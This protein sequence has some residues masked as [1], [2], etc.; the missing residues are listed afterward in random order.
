MPKP[1]VVFMGDSLTEWMPR[2]K[3]NN[4]KLAMAGYSGMGVSYLNH[5]AQQ[6]MERYQPQKV[7]LCIGINDV[8][9]FGQDQRLQDWEGQFASICQ[10]ITTSGATLYGST[11]MPVEKAGFGTALDLLWIYEANKA[12]I[13]QVSGFQGILV[14]SFA[15][16]AQPDGYLPPG[17]SEDGVHLTL[18]TYE[19][20]V[21]FICK[22]MGL[23]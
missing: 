3:L 17:Y 22:S 4:Y 11:L 10:K 1:T 6:I 15:H 23:D 18:A 20:W 7:W 19:K 21:P 16:F 8:W 13:R 12:I 14:D 9:M 5:L 2:P